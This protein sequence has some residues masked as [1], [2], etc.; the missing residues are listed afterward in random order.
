[1]ALPHF[2]M[3][4]V[5]LLIAHAELV[6]TLWRSSHAD[7]GRT[8]L[9]DVLVHHTTCIQLLRGRALRQLHAGNAPRLG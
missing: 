7:T 2:G 9:D 3:A 8:R 4:W 5:E 1:V 6:Q